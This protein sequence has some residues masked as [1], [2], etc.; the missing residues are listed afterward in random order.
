MEVG[1]T[2]VTA[3]LGKQGFFCKVNG[4]GKGLA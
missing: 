1:G 4:K 2:Y 3:H